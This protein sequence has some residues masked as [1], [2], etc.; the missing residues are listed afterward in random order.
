MPTTRTVPD[1]ARRAELALV[2]V[3]V[4]GPDPVTQA[5]LA[6]QLVQPGE[7]AIS[8]RT[9]MQ[10][11]THLRDRPGRWSW[12]PRLTAFVVGETG[13]PGVDYTVPGL[14]DAAAVREQTHRRLAAGVYAAGD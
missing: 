14:D 4:A 8:A 9:M 7:R 13:E 11:L 2:P 5:W 10:A 6:E 12:S 1:L 3:A